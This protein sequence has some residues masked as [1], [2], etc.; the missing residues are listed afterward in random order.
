MASTDFP[1]EAINPRLEQDVTP[2]TSSVPNVAGDVTSY[3][4]VANSTLSESTFAA[5]PLARQPSD[6]PNDVMS[7]VR[8]LPSYVWTSATG[9]GAFTV[10]YPAAELFASLGNIVNTTLYSYLSYNSVKL[11]FTPNTTK[12]YRGLLGVTFMPG[13]YFKTNGSYYT[14]TALSSLP[15]TYIDASSVTSAELTIPYTSFL[16]KVSPGDL[17]STLGH[18]VLWVLDPL[19]CES[20]PGVVSSI[21]INIEASFNQPELHDPQNNG[22]AP[23]IAPARVSNTVAGGVFV[24]AQGPRKRNAVVKE[25]ETKAEK[26]A[27]SGTLEAVSSIA[28]QAS[29]LPVVGGFASGLAVVTSAA[30]KVFDWF[31]MSKPPNLSMPQYL[32]EN[33]M[34]FYATLHGTNNADSLSTELVP[35]ATTDPRYVASDRD[36]C[37]L[38]YL[39]ARPNLIQRYQTGTLS[40]DTP[41]LLGSFPVHPRYGWNQ[42]GNIVPS[43][44][45]L[46]SNL[47]ENW[48]GDIAY[49]F[50]IPATSMTRCR[51]AIMYSLNQQAAFSENNRFMFVE[52]EGTTVVDGVIPHTHQDTYRTLPE[53]SVVTPQSNLSANGYLHVFQMSN[54]VAE[55]PATSPSP[56]SVL[57]FAGG[58]SNTQFATFTSRNACKPRTSG[59]AFP[60]GFLGLESSLSLSGVM[61][62]DNISSV[63]EIMHRPGLYQSVSVPQDASIFSPAGPLPYF[64]RYFFEMFRFWRGSVTFTFM[65]STGALMTDPG[66]VTVSSD[67]NCEDSDAT[68]HWYPSKAPKISYT[69]PWS[70]GRGAGDTGAFSFLTQVPKIYLKAPVYSGPASILRCYISFND[71]LSFGV[72][73]PPKAIDTN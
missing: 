69:I 51:L 62:E 60:N 64:H 13:G 58:T 39:L 14:P 44:L 21:T 48:R 33:P 28:S 41:L 12:F 63:R 35:Y 23:V 50:V 22:M 55:T 49:K 53:L 72:A 8:R 45:A 4:I 11:R 65:Y 38:S 61:P 37:S 9:F 29:E 6:A 10:L 25:A 42:N 19:A 54:L 24:Y 1:N 2:V 17:T 27:I 52:I 40:G 46:V 32:L 56:M 66:F 20:A 70:F 7:R 67:P 57:V 68:T 15:T 31:G 34:P 26:G 71:D 43:N 18:L 36:D 30:S 59:T 47:F 5:A 3:E 16:P 73:C